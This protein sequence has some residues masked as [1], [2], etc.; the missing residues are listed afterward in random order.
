DS[1]QPEAWLRKIASIWIFAKLAKFYQDKIA[2]QSVKKII[3]HI[4][5][6]FKISYKMGF[7]EINGMSDIGIN[8]CLLLLL[9]STE[10]YSDKINLLKTFIISSYDKKYHRFTPIITPKISL[11]HESEFFL[12]GIALNALLQFSK[13]NPDNEI[14]NITEEAFSYYLN[15]FRKTKEG[16]KMLIW[17]SSA[18]TKNFFITKTKKYAEFVFEMNDQIIN[19]Q[20]S[21]D[22]IYPDLIGS[23]S[24]KGSTNV[25]ASIVESL[26]DAYRIAKYYNNYSKMES[27]ERSILMALRFILQSQYRADNT[28]DSNMIGGYKNHFFDRNI[29]VDNIQHAAH[30]LYKFLKYC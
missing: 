19:Q 4:M 28:F 26:I 3:N 25:T 27:Y 21:I 22:S 6:F 8:G 7:I 1:N 2:L 13:I 18:Y 15:L 5:K 12:P 30:A 14:L 24:N 10:F 17:M 29:R 20:I 16:I 11:P 9:L 23:F